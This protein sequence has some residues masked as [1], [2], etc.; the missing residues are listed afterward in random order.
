MNVLQEKP[1]PVHILSQPRY[2]FAIV[3]ILDGLLFLFQFFLWSHR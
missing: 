3:A 1:Q 2:W